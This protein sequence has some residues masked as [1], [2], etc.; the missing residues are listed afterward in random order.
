MMK[1]IVAYKARGTKSGVVLSRCFA[2]ITEDYTATTFEQAVSFLTEQFPNSISVCWGLYNFSDTIFSL[3]PKSTQKEIETKARL[4]VGNVKIFHTRKFLGIT[5][6]DKIKD[7]FY[8]IAENNFYGISHWFPFDN[9]IPDTVQEIEQLGEELLNGLDKLDIQTNKLTSP[10]GVFLNDIDTEG[11]PTIYNL[12][13]YCLQAMDYADQVAGYEWRNEYSKRKLKTIYQ[14]DLTSAYPSFIRDLPNTSC[15][16]VKHSNEWV[17]CDWGI[18]KS[19]LET[20]AKVIPVNKNA[21]YFTTEEIEW[22]EEHKLGKFTIEDGWYFSFDKSRPY[23]ALVEG[24]LKERK[25]KD[26]IVSTL[27][28][29]IAQGLSGKLDQYNSDLSYGEL[30]NPILALMVRSRCRLK[31][32]NFIYDNGLQDDVV[33]VLVDSVYTTKQVDIPSKSL[34]GIFR[35]IMQRGK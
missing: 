11:L 22:V 19:T 12:N 32:G 28:K 7:N 31:V 27:A 29:K 20:T 3:L 15:G 17:E 13:P 34:P 4:H 16:T 21:K 24:L 8:S 33:K 5:V 1:G 25:S 18:V 9:R 23:Q 6:T 26:K 10:I 2:G 35:E 14:Y 30:Y